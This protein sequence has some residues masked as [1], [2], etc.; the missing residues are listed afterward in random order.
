MRNADLQRKASDSEAEVKRLERL[1][2]LEKPAE[3]EEDNDLSAV[4]AMPV[5][6][7]KAPVAT[8]PVDDSEGGDFDNR[9]LIASSRHESMTWYNQGLALMQGARYDEAASSFARFLRMEPEHV[10][11]DRAQFRMAE[12]Q[13]RNHE[14]GLALVAYNQLVSRFPASIKVPESM[15]Q[16]ALS[17]LKMGQTSSAK[18]VLHDLLRQYPMD[19]MATPASKKL[20]ELAGRIPNRF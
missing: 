13:F 20:A 4:N 19:S 17:H 15:Y 16:A 18:N 1:L 6:T 12:C 2:A 10:Y 14:F 3:P 5:T 7:L 8:P 11:A 9:T